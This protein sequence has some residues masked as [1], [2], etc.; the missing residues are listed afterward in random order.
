MLQQAVLSIKLSVITVAKWGGN[1]A[2]SS[3]LLITYAQLSGL[4]RAAISVLTKLLTKLVNTRTQLNYYRMLPVI[5]ALI[6]TC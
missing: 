4:I 1:G 2:L 3:L 5:L 6:A